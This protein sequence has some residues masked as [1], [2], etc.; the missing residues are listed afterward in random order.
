MTR[1]SATQYAYRDTIQY[2]SCL[3][4]NPARSLARLKISQT[5]VETEHQLQTVL[6]DATTR[7]F[8]MYLPCAGPP[9]SCDS[10]TDIQEKYPFLSHNKI[11]S[12][13]L[14]KHNNSI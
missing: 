8:R 13:L 6:R 7:S 5:V 1:R 11:N 9:M 3:Q 2:H 14:Q 4:S 12:L 10:L